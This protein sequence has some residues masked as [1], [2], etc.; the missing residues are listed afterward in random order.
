[1]SDSRAYPSR[2]EEAEFYDRI[3]T[4]KSQPQRDRELLARHPV[5]EGFS[6]WEEYCEKVCTGFSA[7]PMLPIYDALI[8]AEKRQDA[9][10]RPASP[11]PPPSATRQ[12]D[13][14]SALN[15]P[16]VSTAD[17]SI[18]ASLAKL[19]QRV[20]RSGIIERQH[21][22]STWNDGEL[23]LGLRNS[24]WLAIH[25]LNALLRELSK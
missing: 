15:K 6:S 2:R 16:L 7:L 8:D 11:K 4:R 20:E 5:P 25:R 18:R 21:Y 10:Q 19:A 24:E 9:R 13:S 22:D 17:A 3:N 12:A 23:L 1:M 14:P